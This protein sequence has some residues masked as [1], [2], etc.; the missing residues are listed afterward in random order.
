M[1]KVS[2]LNSGRNTDLDRTA[3]ESAVVHSLIVFDRFREF[4]AKVAKNS[5]ERI[6]AVE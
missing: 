3:G 1:T 6:C 4:F 5:L 2:N